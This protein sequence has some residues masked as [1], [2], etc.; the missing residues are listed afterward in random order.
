[1]PQ[2]TQQWAFKDNAVFHSSLYS[3]LHFRFIAFTY[4]RSIHVLI[5]SYH[6]NFSLQTGNIH[7][8]LLR[9]YLMKGSV[10]IFFTIIILTTTRNLYWGNGNFFLAWKDLLYWSY[11]LMFNG[12]QIL[13]FGFLSSIMYKWCI[14]SHTHLLGD[15]SLLAS[16]GLNSLHC[17]ILP[18]ILFRNWRIWNIN[19]Q[20]NMINNGNVLK[21]SGDNVCWNHFCSLTDN[22]VY[23][24]ANEQSIVVER[25]VFSINAYVLELVS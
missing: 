22:P 17:L 4:S 20:C 21:F 16:C 11:S 10:S 12:F 19:N 1:M 8:H 3:L 7:L 18:W 2:F 14:F 25:G 13:H 5:F 6:L 15:L 9:P 24:I 23:I